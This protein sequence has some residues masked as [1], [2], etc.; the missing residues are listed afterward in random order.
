VDPEA[1][2]P[3]AHARRKGE[4][5]LPFLIPPLSAPPYFSY[6]ISPLQ[7]SASSDPAIY[8]FEQ[9]RAS[10]LEIKNI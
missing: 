10:F 4:R 6:Y 1:F 7:S 9:K 3:L 5:P 2:I 8:S